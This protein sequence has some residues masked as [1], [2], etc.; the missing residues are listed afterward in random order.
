MMPVLATTADEFA[1]IFAQKCGR[2]AIDLGG[3]PLVV[4]ILED[5]RRRGDDALVYWTQKLDKVVLRAERMV[6]EPRPDCLDRLDP[7]LRTALEVAAERIADYHRRNLPTGWYEQTEPDI[8]LGVRV[9]PH[10]RVGIYV[11]GGKAAY[12]SS[13]LMCGIPAKVAG[14]DE[15]VMV[16]PPRQRHLPLVIEAAAVLAGVSRIVQVGGA[17][18]IA[19]LAFGTATVPRVDKIVG[20]G[21]RYVAEAKRQ[22]FGIVDIDSVAGPSEVCIVAD[23]SVDPAWVAADAL[24][25][26]EHDEAAAVLLVVTDPGYAEAVQ[27]QIAAQLVDHPR[28]AIA[29][30]SLRR[31]GLIAVCADLDEAVDLANRFAPEHLELCLAEPDAVVERIRHAGAIFIGAHTPEVVGDYL[32]GPNHVLPT[33]GTARFFS[34]LGT[35]DFVKRTSLMSF[36]AEALQ[37]Y[38]PLAARLADEEGLYSH[39]ASVRVRI[40]DGG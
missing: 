15:I 10:E 3:E 32:A 36:G 27:Q 19:A 39:A 4:Q 17:Q 12:P 7:D 14:V 13:V 30:A 1:E 31:N 33:Q 38:G 22:V 37:K 23:G 6:L 2:N 11:P 40:G 34:P 20:P 18:A 25:Q 35:E 28:A 16:T 5:V 29:E 26:A 24:A 21:N 8:S 9:T